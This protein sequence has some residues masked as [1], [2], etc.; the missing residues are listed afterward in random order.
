MQILFIG[1]ERG[2]GTECHLWMQMH[3]VGVMSQVS[4]TLYCQQDSLVFSA[5]QSQ[6]AWHWLRQ[7]D[8]LG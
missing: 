2:N 5:P 4:E 8:T 7:A 1:K 3:Y 6:K